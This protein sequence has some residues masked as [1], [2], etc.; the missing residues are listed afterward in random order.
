MSSALDR[1]NWF[2]YLWKPLVVSGI[3]LG[4]VWILWEV[5]PVLALGV[6][7]MAYGIGLWILQPFDEHELGRLSKL[8]PQRARKIIL[9][10]AI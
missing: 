7:V 4:S 3:S 5:S 8:I 2:H 9:R 6:G 10:R 1:I